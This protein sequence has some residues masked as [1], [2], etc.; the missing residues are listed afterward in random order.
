MGFPTR[1][2]QV[3]AP[4]RMSANPVSQKRLEEAH[5]IYSHTNG[6]EAN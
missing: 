4:E 1:I 6:K 5:E 3:Q 2:S